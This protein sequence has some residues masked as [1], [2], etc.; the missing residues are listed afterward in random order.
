MADPVATLDSKFNYLASKHFETRI[1]VETSIVLASVSD[2]SVLMSIIAS[3]NTLKEHNAPWTYVTT[4]FIEKQ[5]KL[6]KISKKTRIS[7]TND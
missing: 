6:Q 3:V 1:L 4:L 5:K 2:Q 7:L